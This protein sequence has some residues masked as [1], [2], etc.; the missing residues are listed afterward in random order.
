MHKPTDIV[1]TLKKSYEENDGYNSTSNILATGVEVMMVGAGLGD[2]DGADGD[3]AELG[4]VV[5]EVVPAPGH[6]QD[7]GLQGELQRGLGQNRERVEDAGAGQRLELVEPLLPP[8]DAD[9]VPHH[10]GDGEEERP[11]ADRPEQ[12][13]PRLLRLRTGQRAG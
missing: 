7:G 6:H 9:C 1:Q 3:A 4:G 5:G 13:G 8:A 10:Q 2:D 11:E 12:P